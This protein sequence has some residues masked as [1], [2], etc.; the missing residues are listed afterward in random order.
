MITRTAARWQ[1]SDW[2]SLMKTAIRTLDELCDALDLT[3]DDLPAAHQAAKDFVVK[4]PTPFLQRMDKGN[5][6]DPLLL[7]VLPQAAET[8]DVDGFIPD[9]LQEADF[10]K[11]PGLIHKYHGR[12]LLITNPSCVVHCRYCFRRHFPYQEN[13]PGRKHWQPALDY[14]QQD[15][16][17]HEV[18]FSG[19]DP[20]SAN[21]DYLRELIQAIAAI[22]HV[23]TLRLHTRVPVVLPQ[24]ITD[25]LLQTLTNHRLKVLMVLHINHAQEIDTEVS[26]AA[27]LLKNH[28]IRLL[29]QSV[30]LRGINDSVEDQQALCEKLYE[31]DIEAYYLHVLDRVSGTAHFLCDDSQ[32]KNIYT[33]LAGR[34]PGYMIPKLV[35]ETAHSH[36]KTPVL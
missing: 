17:I 36:S 25:D 19:G 3:I 31:T 22:P 29:N 21:D 13:T 15:T 27:R 26:S 11:A 32:A 18:I 33:A 4:V 12:V 28:G 35:R 34:L 23:R 30:F 10:N 14:I 6:Q 7:Q 9:P 16:S 2:Q 24:R 5:P 8:R 20:L 1:T